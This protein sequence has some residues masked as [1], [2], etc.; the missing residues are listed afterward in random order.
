[1]KKNW[2]KAICFDLDDTILSYAAVVDV[3]WRAVCEHFAPQVPGAGVEGLLEAVRSESEW[4]WSD[5]ERHRRGRLDLFAARKGTV[6]AVLRK[7]GKEDPELAGAMAR[8]RTDMHERAIVPFPGAVEAV[9]K[10]REA[11]VRLALITNGAGDAQTRKIDRFGLRPLFDCILIEGEFGC[12]KPDPRVFRQAL[13]AL[14][15]SPEETWMVGD[16]LAMDIAPAQALGLLGVWHDYRKNG[17]PAN[18]PA[19]PNRIIHALSEL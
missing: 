8:M 15:A 6:T 19:K 11:G 18:A 16:N 12:G 10:F 7:F 14:Q 1:M 3:C 2:P 5:P 13:S 9:G 4:F 17:L